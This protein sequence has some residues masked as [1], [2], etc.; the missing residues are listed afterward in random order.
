MQLEILKNTPTKI[1]KGF[2][3]NLLSKKKT[4]KENRETEIATNQPIPATFDN[5]TKVFL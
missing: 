5:I 3:E 2:V 4:I 1:K